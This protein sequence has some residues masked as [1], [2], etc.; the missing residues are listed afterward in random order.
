MR[1]FPFGATTRGESTL[2]ST[3]HMNL[4]AVTTARHSLGAWTALCPLRALHDLIQI[5]GCQECWRDS[6]LARL[7]S[8]GDDVDVMEVFPSPSSPLHQH[9]ASRKPPSEAACQVCLNL[10]SWVILPSKASLRQDVF[11]VK[12]FTVNAIG[13]QVRTPAEICSGIHYRLAPPPPW[14]VR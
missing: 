3:R 6:A 9:L 10:H 2:R 4:T 11:R 7:S 8:R 1:D 14:S 13:E 5:A 12:I